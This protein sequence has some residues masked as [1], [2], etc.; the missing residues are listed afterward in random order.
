[1]CQGSALF[2]LPLLAIPAFISAHVDGLLQRY[3]GFS[4][5][6]VKGSDL[7]WAQKSTV[8]VCCKGMVSRKPS[9][10]S[11]LDCATADWNDLEEVLSLFRGSE[12]PGWASANGFSTGLHGVCS[13]AVKSGDRGRE[14]RSL[15]SSTCP[16]WDMSTIT[17]WLFCI[18]GSP[19]SFYFKKGYMA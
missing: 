2:I 5:N 14:R 19:K 7:V 1:M 10:G 17:Y 6:Q 18:L 13:E 3:S 4:E 9:L 12:R 11:N 16:S 8:L 15:A